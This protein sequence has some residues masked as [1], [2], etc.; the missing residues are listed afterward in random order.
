[1]FLRLYEVGPRDGLQVLN[2]EI[3]LDKRKKLLSLLSEANM[4]YI[5]V[6]S[7]VSPKV[8]PMRDSEH[9]SILTNTNCSMLVLNE[10]GYRRAIEGG[11]ENININISLRD[12]FNEKNLGK[13]FE[14]ILAMYM[15]ILDRNN[16][17]KARAYISHAFDDNF[18]SN[19][20]YDLVDCLS[21]YC[22]TIVLCDTDG[23]ASI[24]NIKHRIKQLREPTFSLALHIHKGRGN[25]M[26]KVRVAYDLGV[27]E[28]D[29]S[30][31]N[32][33]GCINTHYPTANISTIEM[34]RW[35]KEKQIP[36][37]HFIDEEK[38]QE[39]QDYANLMC[40]EASS[41]SLRA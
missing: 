12:D 21:W 1:V 38:L 11:Y 23:D 25:Y 8:L 3:P 28:F 18:P 35:A 30:I 10:K 6:G 15:R 27:R 9:L 4:K 14:E 16:K 17:N 31:V 24:K 32:F 7:C 22:E 34:L 26:E 41:S 40:A 36:M 20:L 39:A 5:E 33:G 19:T 2:H 37:E 29:T 13:G